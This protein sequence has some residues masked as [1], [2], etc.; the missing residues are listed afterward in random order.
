MGNN[1]LRELNCLRDNQK[2]RK[3]NPD[4]EQKRQEMT[5]VERQNQGQDKKSKEVSSTSNQQENENGS[6]SG[7]VCYTVI[8]HSS[9]RRPSLSSNENGYENIDSC[10][11][12]VRS[13]KEGSETEYALLKTTCIT[14][15]PSCTPEHDYELV[16]PY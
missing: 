8:S 5:T 15:P 16:L 7:E 4:V 1:L 3:V 14:R 2:L 12:R 10:A 13:F 6:G 11:K 9:C